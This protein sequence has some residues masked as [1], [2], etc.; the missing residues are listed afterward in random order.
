MYVFGIRSLAYVANA[1]NCS[2]TYLVDEELHMLYGGI[3]FVFE[4]VVDAGIA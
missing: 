2:R 4:V 3:G 1:G